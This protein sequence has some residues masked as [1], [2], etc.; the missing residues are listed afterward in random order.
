MSDGWG[1]RLNIHFEELRTKRALSGAPV[2][3]LEHGLN[4]HEFGSLAAYLHD[5]VRNRAHFLPDWLGWVVY[6]AELGYR[7]NGQDYWST[8]EA[9]TPFW[10][11]YR[12]GRHW[13]REVYKRFHRR[14]QGFQPR[15]AWASQF[16]IIAWPTTHAILP[17][18]LQTQLAETLYRLRYG[19]AQRLNEEAA[20]IGHYISGRGAG[21]SRFRIFLQQE[22]MVGRIALAL[23]GGEGAEEGDIILPVTLRRIVDDLERGQSARAWL[24]DARNEAERA[25]IKGIGRYGGFPSANKEPATPA[26]SLT[27]IVLFPTLELQRL[28]A[29]EWTL[30]AKLPSFRQFGE[31]SPEFANFLRSTRC[32]VE[33]AEGYRP[34]GWLLS[35]GQHRVLTS[36]PNPSVPLIK[37]EKPHPVIDKLLSTDCRIGSGPV[38]VFEIG[39]DGR[40]TQTAPSRLRPGNRY[41]IVSRDQLGDLP[42]SSPAIVRCALCHAALME[43]P[44]HVS[45]EAFKSLRHTGLRV[46][47]TISVWPAGLPARRWDGQRRADWL[48]GEVPSF[49]I[50][51]DHDVLALDVSI[52]GVSAKD[53]P[54]L[55]AGAVLFLSLPGLAQGSHQLCVKATFAGNEE[56]TVSSSVVIDIRIEP[57]VAWSPGST[58]FKG[59]IPVHSPAEPSL[60]DFL[61]GRLGLSVMGPSAYSVNI[62]IELLDA[63]N[64]LL[65]AEQ[66]ALCQLPC[67]EEAWRKASSQFRKNWASPWA[68]LSAAGGN[69]VITSDELGSYRI[70]LRRDVRPVRFIWHTNDKTTRVR[71]LDEN[72][73]GEPIAAEFYPFGA[74]CSPIIIDLRELHD[75]FEPPAPGGLFSLQHGRVSENLVV[76]MPQVASLAEL[77]PR[78][79]EIGFPFGPGALRDTQANL[80]RWRTA[81]L[82]GP[83]VDHRT[84]AITQRLEQHLFRLLCGDSWW[85]AERIYETSAKTEQDLRT[86][87]NKTETSASFSV[88][89]CR[90]IREIKSLSDAD[91]VTRFAELADRYGISERAHSMAAMAIAAAV[92]SGE[93]IAAAHLGALKSL[94][95]RGRPIMRAARFLSIAQVTDL[96]RLD[97]VVS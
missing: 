85:Q 45:D 21:S 14:F 78:P 19:I 42:F 64:N 68:F 77:L 54:S 76:S 81:T 39:S 52:D 86:L 29:T 96:E 35:E 40:A 32:A 61:E 94:G 18:D 20:S 11:Q 33:G 31:T 9:S 34:G 70:A 5:Q 62:S 80:M 6:G 1:E 46:S 24:R 38:W 72:R 10:A 53:R 37:F 23:L 60:D 44:S 66:I 73:S 12:Y 50:S 59:M 84:A 26:P 3:A 36:W 8:F 95:K 75:E 7:F 65:G 43:I 87:A 48:V 57:P 83:L 27:G 56:K 55:A 17:T 16:S 58:D 93:E 41:I 97:R 89:L 92:E 82:A 25:R 79:S 69:I 67:S 51:P 47:R 49:G 71:L 63:G 91:R 22:E 2:F 28:D 90:D 88:L 4:A 13:L 15:G 74:P 30:I